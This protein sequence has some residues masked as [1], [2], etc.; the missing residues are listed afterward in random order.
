MRLN[1]L[2]FGFLAALVFTLMAANTQ[3][4]HAQVTA[5]TLIGKSVSDITE[6]MSKPIEEAITLFKNRQFE[7]ARNRLKSTCK[8]HPQLPPAGVLM[9]QMFVA[10]N[11]GLA[12]R[13]ELERC[14][15]ANPTDPEPYLV[16]GDL[17][18]QNRQITESGLCFDKANDLAQAY[19][20]NPRRKRNLQIRAYAGQAAVAA[21]REQH[22]AEEQ[23][24]TKWIGL[25]PDST[26]AYTR[27]ARCQY[28]QGGDEN[29]RKAYATFGKLYD[30]IDKEK[31][32]T[33]KVPRA[34]INMAVLYSQ[35]GKRDNAKKLMDL[36]L[37]RAAQDDI[38]TRLAVGQWALENGD[39]PMAKQAAGAAYKVD[40]DSLQ[41]ML[42][43]GV[44]ARY[45][46]DATKAEQ[47]FRAA[48]SKT[49]SN[50]AVIN[51]LALTL[52]EQPDET[53][54]RQ[55]LEF[56]QLNQRVNN[57]LQTP[58]GRE[59]AA[60]LSWAAFRLG[61][62]ADAEKGILQVLQSGSVS[63]EAAYHAALIL[64]ERGRAAQ[65]RQILEPLVKQTSF[66]PGKDDAKTM[67]A[68]LASE[69]DLLPSP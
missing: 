50:F 68:K 45:E 41:A 64:N 10:A 24:L 7:D 63:N 65:A 43:L 53:K 4:L 13:G 38:N 21:A 51:N 27:L 66:F 58:A 46:G 18:F 2:A 36:A 31:D 20:A 61:R 33:K 56:A 3:T 67:L 30:E 28:K 12:A 40:P 37:S 1:S 47:W 60:T 34:E 17:A 19:N 42:L 22:A 11:Q 25:E 29:I 69:G 44:A 6:S 57:N 59:A 52:I 32:P 48:H 39:V 49:P 9:A 14:V 55:A 8:A 54:R 16:F 35:E 26:A 62:E 15:L 5:E 23:L